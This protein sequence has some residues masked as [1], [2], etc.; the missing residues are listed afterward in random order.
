MATRKGRNLNRLIVSAETAHIWSRQKFGKINPNTFRHSA[1]ECPEFL[2]KSKIY[3][4]LCLNYSSGLPKPN[5]TDE[6]IEMSE[7]VQRRVKRN[8]LYMCELK[9]IGV[10][11]LFRRFP[12]YGIKWTQGNLY[13]EAHYKYKR[14]Y[15]LLFINTLCFIFNVSPLLMVGVDLREAFPLDP[16]TGKPMMPDFDE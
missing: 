8:I 4:H 7:Q 15:S 12:D 16:E 5:T 2:D 1:P 3:T 11:E 9:G 6:R 10:R 13:R 14:H